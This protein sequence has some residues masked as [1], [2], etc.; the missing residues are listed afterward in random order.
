LVGYYVVGRISA[1]K[2]IEHEG[3]VSYLYVDAQHTTT[4]GT[5]PKK[6]GPSMP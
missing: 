2:G 6:N 4:R 5:A 1:G 3:E